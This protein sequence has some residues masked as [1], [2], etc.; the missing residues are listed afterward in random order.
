MS[1][2][3]PQPATGNPGSQPDQPAPSPQEEPVAVEQPL[4]PVQIPGPMPSKVGPYVIQSLIGSG[5]MSNVYLGNDPATGEPV[6]VKVLPASMAREDGFVRRFQREVEALERLKHPSIVRFISSGFDNETCYL[7]MEYVPG[8]TVMQR[9]KRDKRIPWPE[10]LHLTRQICGAL[11]AAHDAGVIHRDLKPS[12]LLITPQGQVKLTDFGVAQVFAGEKLTITG[13]VIGT[14]EYMS[15]EQAQG[16]RATKRS[17]LYS[18]GALMYVMLTGRPPFTGKTSPEVMQKHL[19]NQFDKAKSYVPDIPDWLDDVVAQLMEKSPDKRFPDA[20]VLLRKLEELQR[21]SEYRQQQLEEGVPA[22]LLGLGRLTARPKGATFA[23]NFVRDE[24]RRMHAPT[25]AQRWL[26]NLWVLLSLLA[27]VLWFIWYCATPVQLTEQEMFQVGS[28]MLYQAPNA[29]WITARDQYFL[30]L[31]TKNPQKWRDKVEPYLEQIEL[32]ELE[33]S[34]SPRRRATKNDAPLTEPERLLR[35]ARLALDGGDAPKA[36]Q[37][38]LSL[39]AL[40]EGNPQYSAVEKVVRRQWEMLQ[41][42]QLDPGERHAFVTAAHERADL[43]AKEGDVVKARQIWL[44]TVRLY[45]DDPQLADGVAIAKRRLKD[46][47]PTGAE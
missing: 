5:G 11:K 37:I 46:I 47:E 38:L 45:E 7:A 13:G 17:D 44:A 9:L 30:P 1:S 26:D 21:L 40:L 27:L 41:Q 36:E 29:D 25:L 18:L 20:G 4:A 8:E 16:H 3:T 24:V 28:R 2:A 35:L 23:R 33:S 22:E 42:R 14:A 32:Y 39:T 15:P 12:N 34:L 31:L 6:A 10:V 43:Y 19:Y